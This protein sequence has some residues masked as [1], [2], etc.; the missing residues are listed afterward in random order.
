MNSENKKLPTHEVLDTIYHE[1]EGQSCF[2]GSHEECCE[3]VSTQN[4]FGLIVVP[5]VSKSKK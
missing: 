3:F 4:S 5:I 1:D 2:E